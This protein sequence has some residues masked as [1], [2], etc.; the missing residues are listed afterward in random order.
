MIGVEMSG[1]IAVPQSRRLLADPRTRHLESD[2]VP[3]HPS[4]IRPDL[5]LAC[6]LL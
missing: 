1:M 4:G 5:R 3:G 6:P 2:L